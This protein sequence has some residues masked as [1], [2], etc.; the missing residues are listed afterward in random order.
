VKNHLKGA[1]V[2]TPP[3]IFLMNPVIMMI[4]IKIF[5]E[6]YNPETK[7]HTRVPKFEGKLGLGRGFS[8]LEE[9]ID[10]FSLFVDD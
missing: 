5:W 9:E 2:V 6:E 7:L 8:K 10:C 1:L 3:S 4:V